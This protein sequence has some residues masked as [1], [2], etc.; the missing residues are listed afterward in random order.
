MLTIQLALANPAYAAV[1]RAALLK[2]QGFE[3]C[4]LE[5]AGLPDVR[6]AGVIVLDS[7]ALEHVPLPLPHPERVVLIA[8]SSPEQLGRAW[9]A[10]IVSVVS[11]KDPIGTVMLAILA[12]R[13]R[14]T[15][16]GVVAKQPP[17]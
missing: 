5:P 1:L 11:E 9:H 14:A 7:E 8:R 10:G 15:R 6:K 17:K 4:M 13:C 16:A 2:E 3:E 12:A